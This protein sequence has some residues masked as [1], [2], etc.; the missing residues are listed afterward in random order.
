LTPYPP[1]RPR[2]KLAGMGTI[3]FASAI[4]TVISQLQVTLPSPLLFFYRWISLTKPVL[5]RNA[6]QN[7]MNSSVLRPNLSLQVPPL[8][9]SI[10]MLLRGDPWLHLSDPD[11]L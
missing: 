1:P 9:P 11:E 3:Q 8:I 7:R 5:R 6:P 10:L 2:K 4:N